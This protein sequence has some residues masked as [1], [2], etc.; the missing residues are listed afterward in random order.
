MSTVDL[1]ETTLFFTDIEASTELW[2]RFPDDMPALVADHDILLAR[3]IEQH[4]GHPF[5]WV[6]DGVCATLPSPRAA[7]AAAAQIQTELANPRWWLSDAHRI[8]ARIAIH[9][10]ECRQRNGDYFGLPIS[11]VARL[12]GAAHGGQVLLSD[13]A[14]ELLQGE[15]ALVDLGRHQLRGLSEPARVFQLI[16]PKQPS[17]FPPLRTGGNFASNLPIPLTRFIGRSAEIARI[18]ALVKDRRLITVTGP[19]G[20]GKTR[21]AVHAAEGMIGRFPG[22]VTLVELAGVTKGE[23]AAFALLTAL[24]R[25]TQGGDPLAAAIEHLRDRR[26]LIILDNCEHLL[27]AC[28]PLAHSLALSCPDAIVIATS[29]EPLRVDGEYVFRL[30]MLRTPAQAETNL[31]EIVGCESVQLLIDRIQSVDPVFRFSAGNAQSVAQVCRRL[32]GIPLALE[33]AASRAGSLSIEQIAERMNDRF[34]LLSR[35]SRTA[36]ARQRTLRAAIDWS[37]DLLSDVERE[38]LVDLSVFVGGWTLEAAEAV[39]AREG[40][41]VADTLASLVERSLVQ[42]DWFAETPRYRLLESIRMYGL[43]RRANFPRTGS[44]DLELRHLRYYC[45]LCKVADS[46]L[47]GSDRSTWMNTVMRDEDN[48]RAAVSYGM[49]HEPCQVLQIGMALWDYAPARGLARECVGWIEFGLERVSDAS[50]ELIAHAHVCAG[51]VLLRL[52]DWSGSRRHYVQALSIARSTGRRLLT[53]KCLFCVGM[54]DVQLD[55]LDQ[56]KPALEEVAALADADGESG[57]AAN[58]LMSLGLMYGKRKDADAMERCLQIA[59]QRFESMGAIAFV[60]L[61]NVNMNIMH[62]LRGD[63]DKARRCLDISL[64]ISRETANLTG[65]MNVLIEFA[66]LIADQ[67]DFETAMRCRAHADRL[68]KQIGVDYCEEDAARLAVMLE[69]CEAALGS[70][71]MAELTAHGADDDLF[72]FCR[73]LTST[74]STVIGDADRGQDGSIPENVSTY[75]GIE[76]CAS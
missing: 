23:M 60:A 69:K 74:C 65:I 16:H 53:L 64:D 13:S 20:C 12:L 30:P 68:V 59:L 54:V 3:C 50:P 72:E 1:I 43:D 6:G 34:K 36:S 39:C 41:D 9:H 45:E 27:D 28:A 63:L 29:R 61:A 8:R 21:L 62:C 58:A 46:G 10:C 14:A 11:Q 7:A 15:T 47:M 31:D 66:P 56:A 19:A 76:L 42:V 2:E 37:F 40:L 55:D 52:Y 48:V 73:M 4:G 75:G 32:D 70:H 33:L 18:R 44:P 5:K 17:S 71:R 22:G 49:E 35:G 24:D 57:L 25:T 38:L 51:D 26:C 67:G